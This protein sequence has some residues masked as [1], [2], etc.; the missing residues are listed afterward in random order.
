VATLETIANPEKL[1]VSGV[2]RKA[3]EEG[4]VVISSARWLTEKSKPQKLSL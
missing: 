3:K 2:A 1:G 4:N